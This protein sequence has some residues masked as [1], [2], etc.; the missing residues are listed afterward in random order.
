M[1]KTIEKYANVRVNYTTRL[2]LGMIDKLKISAATNGEKATYIIENALKEY[3]ENHN[4]FGE[5]NTG[6]A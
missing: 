6:T 4:I 2:P 5:K 3:F 1:D